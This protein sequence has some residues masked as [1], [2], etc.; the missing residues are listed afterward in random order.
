MLLL[1][2]LEA[3]GRRPVR[4]EDALDEGD[5]LHLREVVHDVADLL[6]AA[7]S[8]E[9]LAPEG[10][11]GGSEEREG[12]EGVV[13]DDAVPEEQHLVEVEVPD[14][15]PR[16]PWEGDLERGALDGCEVPEDLGLDLLE[17]VLK[18][19][20]EHREGGRGRAG[21]HSSATGR[22]LLL[23]LLMCGGRGCCEGLEAAPVAAVHGSEDA[24]DV[25]WV[26]VDVAERGA[27]EGEAREGE[28]PAGRVG[29]VA[30]PPFPEADELRPGARLR[31]RRRR[32]R[33]A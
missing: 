31:S 2:A 5:D 30:A 27:E 8:E 11:D 9:D 1:G 32:R 14:K 20:A 23:L 28:D 17:D 21:A 16:D 7:G 26:P 12:Q 24:E 3:E 19:A 29:A 22:C 13:A 4:D 25:S 10:H 18:G 33:R 15:G 6:E